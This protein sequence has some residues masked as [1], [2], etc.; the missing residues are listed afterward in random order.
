MWNKRNSGWQ[1]ECKLELF[2]KKM[3]GISSLVHDQTF[4]PAIS[5]LSTFILK[6]FLNVYTKRYKLEYL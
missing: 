4:M 1:W 5:A 6:K 3:G 2:E